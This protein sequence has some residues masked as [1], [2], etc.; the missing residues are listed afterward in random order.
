MTLDQHAFA[1]HR[2]PARGMD[3]LV[4]ALRADPGLTT[5]AR[6]RL[7]TYQ[8]MGDDRMS[9]CWIS[10]ITQ[11]TLAAALAEANRTPDVPGGVTHV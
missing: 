2:D 10:R 11:T 6:D 7:A 3:S 5:K 1:A 8:A 9:A 4:A